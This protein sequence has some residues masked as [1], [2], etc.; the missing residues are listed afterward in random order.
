M[1]AG[2]GLWSAAVTVVVVGCSTTQLMPVGRSADAGATGPDV[3]DASVPPDATADGATPGIDGCLQSEDSAFFEGLVGK[4][5]TV[6]N[7]L[8]DWHDSCVS[9]S[10]KCSGGTWVANGTSPD[11]GAPPVCSYPPPE[12]MC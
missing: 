11:G 7:A 12:D 2:V 1:R 8:C 4:P 9:C 3:E 10:L 5:C 6:A